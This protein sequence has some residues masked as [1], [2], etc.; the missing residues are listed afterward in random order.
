MWICIVIYRL[1]MRLCCPTE[2][3]V[4]KT[5]CFS[6]FKNRVCR[7]SSWT[8]SVWGKETSCSFSECLCDSTQK[9]TWSETHRLGAGLCRHIGTGHSACGERISSCLLWG[10]RR[11][12]TL[13]GPKG[14]LA[15][16]GEKTWNIFSQRLVK[17]EPLSPFSHKA[18][19]IILFYIFSNDL[20]LSYTLEISAVTILCKSTKPIYWEQKNERIINNMMDGSDP[21]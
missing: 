20:W 2:I 16:Q 19:H 4:R 3:M 5:A 14:C 15:T 12:L 9:S 6:H 7:S 18:M 21:A 13:L 10:P 8:V 11:E 17:V 1:P